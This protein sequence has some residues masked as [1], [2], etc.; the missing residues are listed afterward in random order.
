MLSWIMNE[1]N[2]DK[3]GN[4]NK[5]LNC[6]EVISGPVFKYYSGRTR[7]NSGIKSEIDRP[8]DQIYNITH[9]YY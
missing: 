6:D 5:C 9:C 1:P 2:V 3:D 7:R 8:S 4:L